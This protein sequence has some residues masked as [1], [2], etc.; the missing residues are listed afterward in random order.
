MKVK[1]MRWVFV[2]VF[3]LVLTL[4]VGAEE[5]LRQV[6]FEDAEV[7][8]VVQTLAHSAGF[9][10]ILSGDQGSAQSKKT[11]IHLKDVTAEE[12]IGAILR[13]SGF[14]YEKQG[15]VFMVSALSQDLLQTGYKPEMETFT[16]KYLA[17]GKAVE[18]LSKLMPAA[19]FQAGSRANSLLVRGRRSEIEEARALIAS[20]DKLAPQILIE[21]QVMELAQSDSMHLGLSY[22]SGA[23][24]FI[25]D[26]ITKKTTP[27]DNL[28]TTLNALAA[29]GRAKVVANPRIATL[30]NQEALINIGDR[31]PY[32]V[33]VT[34]GGITTQ[35]TVEYIDAGVKL[36]IIPQLG[37]EG[38]ITTLIQ[39]EISAISEWRTTPAGDFPVIST[40][41]AAATVRVKDG[42]TIIIGGLLSDTDRVNI[43]RVPILGYIPLVGLL[44]QDRSVEKTKTEIVFLITPHVI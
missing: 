16:L 26:K 14:C 21:S 22:G 6:D 2:I 19:L 5:R 3:V 30:D 36:K 18:I 33:P 17:A 43:S 41:N 37:A 11:T 38:Y 10:V 40:R 25:T 39:P 42:E 1:E 32:A 34:S 24:K 23:Y 28:V 31:I 35:W 20:I 8:G 7:M 12:A 4:V 13:T 44:F 15:K 29:D 9:D 27:A